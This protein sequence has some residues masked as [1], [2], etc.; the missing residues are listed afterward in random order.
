MTINVVSIGRKDNDTKN[1][2]GKEKIRKNHK[3]RKKNVIGRQQI[4]KV[5]S[6]IV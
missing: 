5:L 1:N 3:G 2:D 4:K 6:R